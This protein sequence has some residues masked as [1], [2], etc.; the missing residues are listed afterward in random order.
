MDDYREAYLRKMQRTGVNRYDRAMKAKQ[1]E[2]VS[3]FEGALNREECYIDGNKAYAVFQDHS[4]SNNKDLSDDKYVI[5][6]N[7]TKAHVGSYIQWREGEWLVFTEEEK[8]I[9]THQQMKIK[10]VNWDV[11]WVYDGEVV[12]NGEGYGA[13]VQNQTLYTLGV[14]FSGDNISIV[15]GKMMMYM[16]NNVDTRNIKIGK[17]IFIGDN[18]YK[19]LFTDPISRNGLINFLMEEDT[20]TEDDNLELRIA[21]YWNT[22]EEPEITI[23][24]EVSEIIG[25]STAK[26]ASIQTYTI[27]SGVE[28]KEWNIE[29]IDGSEQPFYLME[30][31][32]T[33][34]SLRFKDDFRF[35]GKTTTIIAELVN[36]EFISL[37]V[38]VVKKF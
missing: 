1:R 26:L 25:S 2:F 30:R 9:P 24:D 7:E 36:G 32:S 22:V 23:P 13:Y 10:V 19:I 34:L 17:R 11:K 35:V 28:V 38:R 12:N 4:Q 5:L 3:Y 27:S 16:Q 14:A 31:T 18:V 37:P 15:N 6:P 33:Q 29:S 8:T 20:I 21:D